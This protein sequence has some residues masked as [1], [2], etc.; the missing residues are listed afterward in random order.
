MKYLINVLIL[1]LLANYIQAQ[2]TIEEIKKLTDEG[3]YKIALKKAHQ[4]I[5]EDSLDA[6]LWNE[7]GELQVLNK[8]YREA[9]ESFNRSLQIDSSEN[10]TY[11]ALANAYM[12]VGRNNAGIATYKLLLQ[13]DSCN[14]AAL[15]KLGQIYFKYQPNLSYIHYE[16]LHKLDTLNTGYLLMMARCLMAEKEAL[17][18]FVLLKDIFRRDTSNIQAALYLNK[19]Y[20]DMNNY[21]TAMLVINTVIRQ[22]PNE[23]HL[24]FRRG[25]TQFKKNYHFRSAP[26]FKKAIELGFKTDILINKLAKSLFMTKKYRESKKYFDELFMRQDTIDYLACMYVGNIYNELNEPDSAL[27]FFDKSLQLINPDP[28]ILAQLNGGKSVSYKLKKDYHKQIKYIKKQQEYR[29]KR[30]FA[31]PYFLL[32]IAKIYDE[33]LHEK[34]L[35]LRYYSEYYERTKDYA[36]MQGEKKEKLLARINRL[37]EELHFE[38]KN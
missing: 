38:A 6:K 10:K 25:S 8:K 12:R 11:L 22:Y 37:K 9:A 15:S 34:K 24:Y 3:K 20:S 32:E 1:L 29:K 33:N 35:A 26:D 21:D 19:M 5:M 7:L 18:A 17:K 23:G 27:L 14:I 31:F 4:L 16:K 2:T 13:K 36:F 28:L 30:G